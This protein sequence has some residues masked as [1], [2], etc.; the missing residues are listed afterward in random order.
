MPADI[1]GN[2]RPSGTRVPLSVLATIDPVLRDTA[3]FGLVTDTPRSVALR[4]DL[5]AEDGTL[6]RV[7]VDATGVVEDTLVDLEHACLSCAVRE[8]AIPTLHE[9]AHDGRW[10]QV[11]LAL[12]VAAEPLPVVRALDAA[13]RPG[14]ALDGLRLATVLTVV[15]L[16]AVETDLLDDDLLEERGGARAPPDP[17]TGGEGRAAQ[18][19]RAH[20]GGPTGAPPAPARPPPPRG[21]HP[22]RT[23]R[24]ASG[25]LAGT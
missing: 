2:P 15:D 8:D 10:D 20:R 12:P 18:G 3:I 16:A 1:P 4:H 11:L 24:V 17:P 19:A 13:A 25:N 22:R 23:P 14:G 5:H 21:Q 7:V 6:R 9:L